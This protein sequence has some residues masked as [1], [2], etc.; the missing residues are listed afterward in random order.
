MASC[1]SELET[2][3]LAALKGIFRQVQLHQDVVEFILTMGAAS[4]SDFYGLVKAECYE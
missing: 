4:V 2:R 3:E 1:S